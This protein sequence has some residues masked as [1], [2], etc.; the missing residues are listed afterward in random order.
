[1]AT[2]K[3]KVT[4]KTKNIKKTINLDIACGFNKQPHFVGMDIRDVEGV[5]IVHDLEKTPWPVEESIVSIALLSHIL[6]H[7]DPRRFLDVMAELWRVC[8]PDASVMIAVP[9]ANSFGGHQDPTHMR[10]GL[11][12]GTWQY[13]D[14]RFFLWQIYKP[15]PF[16]LASCEYDPQT[17]MEVRM[18]CI[19][20]GSQSIPQDM[21]EAIE[22]HDIK[23]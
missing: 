19:K 13:F 16:L 21:Q 22:K 3:K 15:P 5:D 9:Y 23:I 7:I 4:K 10:P 20:E 18:V 6:E 11:N 1:M 2:K 8:V 17:N 14:P 12:E